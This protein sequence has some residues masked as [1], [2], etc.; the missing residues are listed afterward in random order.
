MVKKRKTHKATV[1][2][3]KMSKSGKMLHKRQGNNNHYMT[4]KSGGRKL[5]IEGN[6]ALSSKKESKKIRILGNF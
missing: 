5:R 4:K 3:F 6:V 2:R 1:K